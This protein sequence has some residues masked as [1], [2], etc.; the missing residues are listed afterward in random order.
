MMQGKETRK[1]EKPTLEKGSTCKESL[2][3]ELARALL[4]QQELHTQL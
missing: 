3:R 2:R 4:L 1:R